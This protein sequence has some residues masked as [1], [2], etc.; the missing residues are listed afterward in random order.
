MKSLKLVV[1]L[2]AMGLAFSANMVMA[3]Q[4]AINTAPI[5]SA[6]ELDQ[7]I[8]SSTAL[9]SPLG[10]LSDSGLNRFI[11]SMTFNEK[12]LT[13]YSYAELE[14]VPATDVHKILSLFGVERTT[15]M[16]SNARI[17]SIRDA[18]IMGDNLLSEKST[19]VKKGSLSET[20]AW[21]DVFNPWGDTTFAD[22]PGF[23]CAGK[24]SCEEKS[25]S[26][27]IGANC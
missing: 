2:V 4:K 5:M 9:N 20:S 21:G 8:D 7:H 26:I 25:R 16:I 6:A 27:C 23:Y 24:G 3:A 13:G 10:K 14:G 19:K 15:K 22:Y 17:Q 11:A 12:G 1:G 18:E